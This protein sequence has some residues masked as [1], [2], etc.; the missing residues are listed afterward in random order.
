[1]QRSAGRSATPGTNT[2]TWNRTTELIFPLFLLMPLYMA[3]I[4]VDSSSSTYGVIER[5]VSGPLLHLVPVPTSVSSLQPQLAL[6]RLH[7]FFS[8]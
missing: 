7:A 8:K 2:S 3:A 6:S 4:H 5:M 1:M